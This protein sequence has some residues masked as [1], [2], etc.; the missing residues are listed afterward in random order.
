MKNPKLVKKNS[1]KY[2]GKPCI[3][4]HG[5]TRYKA[6]GACIVCSKENAK[7]R[8]A[9][10]SGA[11]QAQR[12]E[13]Y[14]TEGG[15]KAR[16]ERNLLDNYGITL[17]EYDYMVLSQGDACAICGGPPGGSHG[18]FH[19]DHDHATGKVRSLLCYKCNIGLGSF[20]DSPERLERAAE[21]L[22]AHGRY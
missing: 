11:W 4:G 14:A 5:T 16:R 3:H 17:D 2:E 10:P 13:R 20:D 7:R 22:R 15:A 6:G 21:Y 9:D 19:V 1:G 18:R 8:W 12:R